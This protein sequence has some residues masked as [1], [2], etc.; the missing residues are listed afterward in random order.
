MAGEDFDVVAEGEEFGFDAG[1]KEVAVATREVPAAYAAGE[2]DVATEYEV[3]GA[4]EET[5]AAGAVAGDLEDL[6]IVATEGAGGGFGDHEIGGECLDLKGET[7]TAEEL[8]IG[9][10]GD[11]LG[12]AADG[13]GVLAVDAGGIPDVIN[14]AV[15]EEEEADLVSAFREPIGGLLGG[16]DE[17]A[18]LRQEEAIR[19]EHSAGEAVDG[20]RAD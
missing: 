5:E 12:V 6:E 17:D 15:G 1:E 14:V 11:G 3:V 8:G 4:R 10:H 18:C 16:V 2:E 9:D 20:H 13:A 7:E 19:L